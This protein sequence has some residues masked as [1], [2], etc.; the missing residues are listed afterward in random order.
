MSRNQY[1][2]KRET[3]IHKQTDRLN[4]QID[5]AQNRFLKLLLETFL[6]NL[7]VDENGALVNTGNSIFLPSRLDTFFDDFQADHIKPIVSGFASNAKKLIRQ[8]QQY[9]DTIERSEN[10][11]QIKE[12]VL[13]AIGISGSVVLGGSLLYNILSNRSVI[14]SVKS[15]VLGAVNSSVSITSLKVSVEEVVLKKEGGLFKKMFNE[16]MP[17]PYVKLDRFIGGKY[18]SDLNLT[19]AIYQGGLIKTSRPFCI[20]R[21]N[22]VFS[23][24]EIMKFGTPYDKYGGYSDKSRGEFQGKTEPYDPLT[25]LG[26]FNCRHQFD[27]ISNELAFHLRPDL[28]QARLN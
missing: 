27:W 16:V 13:S 18:A 3:F 23:R 4:A 19:Y 14:Q 5:R 6:L 9:F 25:D 8:N 10:H 20:E 28:K 24:D 26:G 22:R 1:S 21:N 12:Q 11:D 15:M 2:Q 7:P 17:D